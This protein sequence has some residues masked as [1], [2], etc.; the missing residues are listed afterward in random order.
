MPLCR[1]SRLR[2]VWVLTFCAGPIARILHVALADTDLSR[3]GEEKKMDLT[4][5]PCWKQCETRASEE[6]RE[7]YRREMARYHQDEAAHL[8]TEL[9]ELAK[10]KA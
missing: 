7:A 2:L 8:G 10:R 4:L 5:T 3:P 6:I 9:Q 1:V